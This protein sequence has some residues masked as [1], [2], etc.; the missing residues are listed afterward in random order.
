MINKFMVCL[1]SI[2]LVLPAL[3]QAKADSSGKTKHSQQTKKKKEEHKMVAVIVTSLGTIEAE[4]YEK[5]APNT[6]ANFAG[7][8]KEGFY[9]GIIFHRVVP[10]FVIQGGDPTG[11]GTGGKSIYGHEFADE[12]NPAT[13]SYQEGYKKGVLAMANHGPNTN[14]SQFFI[15]LADQPWMPK[16]YTIFGKV[17][18]G[19][20]VVEKIGKVELVPPGAKDGKPKVPVT[21]K[22]VTVTTE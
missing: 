1:L 7:L 21:M 17:I 4:L 13:K 10:G 22:K 19:M 6:V 12:L 5:D 16:N 15:L 11:T 9:N 3:G 18:K 8:A 2:V 14:S 20:D